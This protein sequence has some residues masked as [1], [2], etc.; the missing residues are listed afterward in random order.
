MKLSPILKSL[1]GRVHSRNG[2]IF[3]WVLVGDPFC[4]F[5]W[6]FWT[7]PAHVPT[8]K[9]AMKFFIQTSPTQKLPPGYSWCKTF[10][11]GIPSYMGIIMN[12]YEHPFSKKQKG[13]MASKRFSFCSFAFTTYTVHKIY[14]LV[15]PSMFPIDLHHGIR[16]AN[17]CRPNGSQP[18]SPTFGGLVRESFQHAK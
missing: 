7:L 13:I 2:N 5:G 9:Q 15:Y 6:P 1:S 16:F 17:S 18:P 8:K 11:Y 4:H 10:V 14:Y 12:H 3:V